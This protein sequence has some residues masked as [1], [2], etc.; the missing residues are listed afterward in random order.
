[1]MQM[2]FGFSKPFLFLDSLFGPYEKSVHHTTIRLFEVYI[3]CE[4]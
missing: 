4:M 1:M 3:M 2:R